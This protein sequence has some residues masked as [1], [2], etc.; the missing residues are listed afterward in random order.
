MGG[1]LTSASCVQGAEL[2]PWVD[3]PP[4]EPGPVRGRLDVCSPTDL[5]SLRD[6]VAPEGWALP[7]RGRG[8]TQRHC[9]WRELALVL[10]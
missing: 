5:A 10:N 8:F 3:G 1:A 7:A 2:G 4:Q 6:V 9:G